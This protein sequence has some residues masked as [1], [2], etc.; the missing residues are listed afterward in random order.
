MADGHA[1]SHDE[2][3]MGLCRYLCKLLK[4]QGEI[5]VIVVLGMAGKSMDKAEHSGHSRLVAE[6]YIPPAPPSQL[7]PRELSEHCDLPHGIKRAIRRLEV[8]PSTHQTGSHVVRSVQLRPADVPLVQLFVNSPT[9][10]RSRHRDIRRQK[11]LSP[12]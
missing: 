11:R 6:R 2:Y 1:D 8:E 4:M 5:V 12:A 10:P 9:E 3:D 7:M